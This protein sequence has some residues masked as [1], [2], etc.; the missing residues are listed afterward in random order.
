VARGKEACGTCDYGAL[1]IELLKTMAKDRKEESF[2]H[3]VLHAL[4]EF[5]NVPIE[6]A[7]EENIVDILAKGLFAFVRDNNMKFAR[8]PR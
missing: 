8:P 7:N 3:E 2:W 5:Y 6:D 4:V 1:E